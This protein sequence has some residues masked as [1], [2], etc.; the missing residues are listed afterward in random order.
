MK[1]V[2][3]GETTVLEWAANQRFCWGGREGREFVAG[4]GCRCTLQGSLSQQ[5]PWFDQS[6]CST[7]VDN[8]NVPAACPA[9]TGVSLMQLPAE[10]EP[11]YCYCQK[12]SHGEMVAC[13][14]DECALEWFHYECVGLTAAPVGEWY[15]PDCVKIMQNKKAVK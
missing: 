5:Q 15:C 6:T 1:Q 9:V 13:D 11:V 2:R 12:P 7:W 8:S 14:H 10:N 3:K 4:W